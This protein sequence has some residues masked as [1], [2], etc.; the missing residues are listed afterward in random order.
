MKMCAVLLQCCCMGQT[1]TRQAD[2]AN[3][4]LIFYDC[5]AE[6]ATSRNVFDQRTLEL[7]I[8]Y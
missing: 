8:V 2:M 7:C 3:L 4:T 6:V 1:E 5:F